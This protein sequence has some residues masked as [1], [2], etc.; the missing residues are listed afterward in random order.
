ML[1]LDEP[2]RA[3]LV[4]NLVVVVGGVL[5]V[6]GLIFGLGWG[7][8]GGAERVSALTPP[9]WVVGVVW[10][11]LFAL[12]AVARWR[13]AGPASQG[14]RGWVTG[15]IVFCLAYP[16]YAL[17]PN[18]MRNAFLGS[19]G[20]IALAGLVTWRVWPISRSA[21]A[22][23]LPVVPWVVFATGTILADW[24]WFGSRG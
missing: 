21:A 10:T 8:R 19:L 15:L 18:S 22:C 7:D 6:N 5:A 4:A 1:R 16:F 9:G 17:A 2:G 24:G 13:L 14:G 20:T 23:V 11:G 3:G 12:L